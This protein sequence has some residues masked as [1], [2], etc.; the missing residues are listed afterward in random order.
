MNRA[1]L[2]QQ[3]FIEAYAGNATEAARIAGYRCPM[4]QGQRLLRKDEISN[5]IKSRQVA[6]LMPTILSRQER[7]EFWSRIM[8]NENESTR[9][10]L[11]ASELLGKSEADFTENVINQKP[12]IE[13]ELSALSTKE[14]KA[15]YISHLTPEF[16]AEFGLVWKSD[17]VTGDPG[18]GEEISC[19]KIGEGAEV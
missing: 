1:T 15:R 9:D 5:A 10:R 13:D 11:R 16:M 8:M 17:V 6:E 19:G 3:K 18:E 12:S 14:L 2:K 4:Q 7:Q